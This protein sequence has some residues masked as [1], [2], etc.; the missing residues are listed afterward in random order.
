MIRSRWGLAA[1]S[2]YAA[3]C[4]PVLRTTGTARL[5]HVQS[6]IAAAATATR[7]AP[8]VTVSSDRRADAASLQ[9][10]P[11]MATGA[12]AGAGSRMRVTAAW[13]GR[14]PARL[15]LSGSIEQGE[16]RSSELSGDTLTPG[17]AVAAVRALQLRADAALQRQ[18]GRRLRFDLRLATEHSEG[19]GASR[20]ALPRLASTSVTSRAVWDASRRTVVATAVRLSHEQTGT[21]PALTLARVATSAQWRPLAALSFSASAGLVGA[22][23]GGARPTIEAGAG[24]GVPTG[25]RLAM[26]LARTAE[27]DRLDGTLL[28]RARMRVRFETPLVQRVS[29]GGTLQSAGDMGGVSQRHVSSGDA[30]FALDAGHGRKVEILMARFQQYSGGRMTNAETRAVLQFSFAPTR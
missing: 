13:S 25:P 15:S 16:T 14:V 27:V 28:D 6:S 7:I 20:D 11:Q 3:A 1:C 9:I 21:A 17:P 24:V 5:E 12:G 4:A 2:L 10:A 22:S 8:V 18:Q 19:L 23:S 29:F 26:T 30:G